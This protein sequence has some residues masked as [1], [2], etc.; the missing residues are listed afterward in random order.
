VADL[1]LSE[2]LLAEANLTDEVGRK[3]YGD[4]AYKGA[5]LR[6]ALAEKNLLLLTERAEQRGIRQQ[7]EIAFAG[8]KS[9]FGL[10]W[11]LAK[12]LTG[13]VMRVVAKITAYTF[14][15]YINRMLGRPQGKIKEL[16]A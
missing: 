8:L 6:D 12:T 7:I 15:L 5:T 2:E 13:I 16:W 1:R 9:I 11:T 14:G 4:L 3:L 10:G